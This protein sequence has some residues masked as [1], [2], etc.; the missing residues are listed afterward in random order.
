MDTI[1]LGDQRIS[2]KKNL[3]FYLLRFV[4]GVMVITT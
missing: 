1:C 2:E 4:P 3:L